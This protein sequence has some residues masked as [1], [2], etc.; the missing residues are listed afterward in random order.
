[1]A[2]VT[3]R[4]SPCGRG[5]EDE[6]AELYKQ[7]E[8][9]VRILHRRDSPSPQT[10]SP[11]R[12]RGSARNAPRTRS[13][14]GSRVQLA[15][16]LDPGSR[17]SRSPG[18]RL[19]RRMPAGRRRSM[20]VCASPLTLTLSPKGEREGV[21]SPLPWGRGRGEGEKEGGW[22]GEPAIQAESCKNILAADWDSMWSL[23]RS[24]STT[25]WGEIP[26]G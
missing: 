25:S 3:R 24:R 14:P 19:S 26:S 20:V 10:L 23:T 12:G 15:R 11:S 7:G 22:D 16:R 5:S 6:A 17:A 1:M 18:E 13:D 21:T 8:G 2:L 9:C 4:L